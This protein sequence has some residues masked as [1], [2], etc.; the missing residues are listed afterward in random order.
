[1]CTMCLAAGT[2]S[3]DAVYQHGG[4]H[5]CVCAYQLWLALQLYPLR[6]LLSQQRDPL[7]RLLDWGRGHH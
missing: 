2:D 5:Q 4:Q 3:V 1:M 6:I 7:H